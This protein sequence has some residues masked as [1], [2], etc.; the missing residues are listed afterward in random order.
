M[1][2][3]QFMDDWGSQ[4]ALLISPAMWRSSYK[5]LYREY[6]DIIHS[7]GK[8]A[9]FHSDG[10]IEAIYP[11]LVEIGI[12]AVNSQ[13]FCMDIERLAGDFGGKITFW[14]EIDRQNLLPFGT[15]EDVRQGVRRVRKAMDTGKGGVI[16][17]CE[18]GVHDPYENVRAV[19][20]EWAKPLD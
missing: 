6:V 11:D 5:P 17:Q 4:N 7:A 20:D 13:L 18:W 14:G 16:A 8:F 10:H 2:G 9:F 3:I 15:E 1:D 19:F 12:D